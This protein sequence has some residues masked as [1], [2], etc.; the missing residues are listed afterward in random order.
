[1][2]THEIAASLRR[3]E[4][5][6]RRRPKTGLG[7]DAPAT[8]RWEDGMRVVS[9]HE[10]GARVLTDLPA[11]LGGSG[12]GVTPGW[13]LRAGLAS[14]AATRIA[15]AAAAEGIDLQALE[16]VAS[17]RSDTRGLLGMSDVDG[18]PVPAGPSDVQLL[19]RIRAP[20]VPQERLRALVENSHRCSPVS[21][22]VQEAVPVGLRIEF[23][24][25]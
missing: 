10:N 25:G 22:A 3:V 1:M 12:S 21:C 18:E 17:S 4:S 19:V 8:A 6:L 11:A 14:C 16:L 23:D 13:L 9:S 7:E 5:V 2:A 20:G 15:M 24:A